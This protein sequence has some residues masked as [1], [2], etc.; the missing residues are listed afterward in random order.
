MGFYSPLLKNAIGFKFDP[1]GSYNYALFRSDGSTPIPFE[2]WVVD[3]AAGLLTFYGAVPA[4]MPPRISFYRYVGALGVSGAGLPTDAAGVTV[5]SDGAAAVNPVNKAEA[6]TG[7]VLYLRKEAGVTVLDAASPP[8][9]L[10]GAAPFGAVDNGGNT[11]TRVAKVSTAGASAATAV[12]FPSSALNRQSYACALV[13]HGSAT[14]A[15]AGSVFMI[16]LDCAMVFPAPP[17][18]AAA[19]L[20][21]VPGARLEVVFSGSS[22]DAVVTGVAGLNIT[23]LVT[24]VYSQYRVA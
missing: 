10:S 9:G 18:S 7:N 19:Y 5:I 2:E 23:W 14:G 11:T 15:G 12:S 1:A 20:G 21:T 3:P 13:A 6:A 22:Y 4:G 24:A 17:L 8:G 16:K